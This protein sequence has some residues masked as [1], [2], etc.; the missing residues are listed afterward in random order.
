[1]VG[2]KG[3][4]EVELEREVLEEERVQVKKEVEEVKREGSSRRRH[5]KRR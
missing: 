4:E 2:G 3:V 1:M 5:L